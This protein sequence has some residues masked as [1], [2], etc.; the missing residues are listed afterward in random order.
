[1]RVELKLLHWPN[2]VVSSNIKNYLKQLFCIFKHTHQRGVPFLWF[3]SQKIRRP[4]WTSSESWNCTQR[5]CAHLSQCQIQLNII[6]RRPSWGIGYGQICMKC[7]ELDPT[8]IH[9]LFSQSM[10]GTC[11][12]M[13]KFQVS[14]EAHKR[15]T[16]LRELWGKDS[17]ETRPQS[18]WHETSP[19]C[20]FNSCISGWFKQLCVSDS[21]FLHV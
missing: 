17:R 8:Q 1:M 9:K 14:K 7:H 20:C 3:G 4:G 19:E 11:G 18:R 6:R 13:Q 10:V 5:V 16:W 2:I 12:N 21:C 15:F